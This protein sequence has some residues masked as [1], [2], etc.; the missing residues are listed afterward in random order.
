MSDQENA[1]GAQHQDTVGAILRQ[2]REAQGLTVQEAA[3]RLRLMNRQIE[4]MD[5]DDF[6]VLG[7]PVFA[8]GFVRNYARLLGLDHAA[9]LQQMGGDSSEPVEVV[10]AALIEV[11]GSWLSSPW[12]LAVGLGVLLLITVPIALYVW[13]NSG[14]E[15]VTAT[16]HRRPSVTAVPA[17]A[18]VPKSAALLPVAAP[19]VLPV[20]EPVP[21]TPA[22]PQVETA[23]VTPP[24]SKSEMHFEFAADAWVEI[25]DAT[26]RMVHRQMNPA[27]SSADVNGQ[28]P[29]NLVIGNA[30]QV[31]MTYNGRPLDLAPFIEIKVARFSLEE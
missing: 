13:L 19:P 25:R 30:A 31:R 3:T 28:P 15:E 21:V 5:A 26:G 14:D 7:Q 4:A 20:V 24:A 22:A 11:S 10:Q 23:T 8:R 12:L 17:L 2:A 29:F 18:V 6:S 1:I 27:G 9:L 16:A